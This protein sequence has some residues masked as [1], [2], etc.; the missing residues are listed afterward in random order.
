MAGTV[1][2][3]DAGGFGQAVAFEDRQA[4]CGEPLGNAGS[5]RS[6]AGEQDLES[7]PEPAA[8]LGEDEAVSDRQLKASPDRQFPAR[9]AAAHCVAADVEGPSEQRGAKPTGGGR[10]RD[11]SAV[12]LLENARRSGHDGRLNCGE[13]VDDLVDAS[14]DGGDE[15]DLVLSGQQQLSE[16]VRQRQPEQLYGVGPDEMLGG[17]GGADV[18]PVGV[19]QFDAFGSPGGAGCVDDGG[20]V[21]RTCRVEDVADGIRVRQQAITAEFAQSVQS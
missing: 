15:P 8:D 12:D 16:D 1:D 6:A 2:E 13:V 7:P 9:L 10:A 5:Q 4:G 19:R 20:Q 11:D 3:R 21:I 18:Q 17:H 14:V